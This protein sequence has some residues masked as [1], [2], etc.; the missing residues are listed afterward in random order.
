MSNRIILSYIFLILTLYFRFFSTKK[1]REILLY[2]VDDDYS[3]LSF[4]LSQHFVW[5]YI[6][7]IFQIDIS[8]C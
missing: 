7:K 3:L 6:I 1:K 4:S 5:A 8:I 2:L